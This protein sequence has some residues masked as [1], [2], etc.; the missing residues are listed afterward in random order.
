MNQRLTQRQVDR[1][2]QKGRFADAGGSGL[3][4]LVKE[5][6]NY[7][8]RKYYI[9]RLVIKGR[10]TDIS[11]GSTDTMQ[12]KEARK[13]AQ[14]NAGI[15]AAGKDPRPNKLKKS[16]RKSALT[17]KQASGLVPTFNEVARDLY[18]IM[19]SELSERYRD[20]WLS[21]LKKHAKPL[22]TMRVDQIRARHVIEIMLT[23]QDD[24]STLWQGKHKTAHDL[25]M[26]IKNVLDHALVLEYVPANVALPL[27]AGKS[28][29]KV[30]RQVK[31]HPAVDH[32]QVAAALATVCHTR[33]RAI[34]KDAFKFM[35][36]TAARSGEVRGATWSE[37]D[38]QNKVWTIPG[39]RMK[40][41]KQH[42]VPLSD[43]AQDI[44]R[45]AMMMAHQNTGE[46]RC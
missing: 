13:K 35:V 29:P 20:Q 3:T 41:G 5:A 22:L 8:V 36:Y 40:S 18:Q 12:L 37:I 2:T 31:H 30:R 45:L 4:L 38:W 15:V 11:L 7:G 24:G 16:K 39:E 25:L 32:S 26:K 27:R 46:A 19:S 43:A 10:R 6:K 1:A 21:S 44:L 14:T 33:S 42:R 17:V 23:N 34:T 28:L 9:Q